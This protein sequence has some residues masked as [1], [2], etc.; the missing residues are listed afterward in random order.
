[1]NPVNFILHL[2]FDQLLGPVWA[3]FAWIMAHMTLATLCVLMGT[4]FSLPQIYGLLRPPAFARAARNFP[5]SVMPGRILMLLAT[6]WFL[7][8]VRIESLADFADYKEYLMLLFLA[9]GVGACFFV[10]DYLAVRGLALVV[11]LLAKLMVDTGRLHLAGNPLVLVIQGW[12][13]VLVVAGIWFTVA[14][15][16]FRDLLAWGTATEVRIRVGCGI[17]LAYGIFVTTLGLAAF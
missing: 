11:F 2:I 3:I 1:M 15:W 10:Q 13:Y 16:K 14:P 5:R 6:L 12:A 4:G 17:R 9:T 7:Y 8:Y